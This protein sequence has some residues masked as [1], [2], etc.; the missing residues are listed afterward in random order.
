MTANSERNSS[1]IVSDADWLNV[2]VALSECLKPCCAGSIARI[3][4]FRS[5]DKY[6]LARE[7]NQRLSVLLSGPISNLGIFRAAAKLLVW[8]AGDPSYAPTDLSS[9]P[10]CADGKLHA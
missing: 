6:P 5:Q 9:F 10:L 4:P 2:S 3:G 1:G 8:F 7:T